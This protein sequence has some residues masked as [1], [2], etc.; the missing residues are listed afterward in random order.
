M[1]AAWRVLLSALI[2]APA[3]AIARRQYG[4]SEFLVVLKRSLLPGLVLCAH[5]ITW[6]IGARL[7]LGVNATIIVSLVPLALPVLMWGMFGEVLQKRE[8]IATLLALAGLAVLALDG[9]RMSAEH[10]LGDA[11]C[12]LSM[13]LFALYLAMARRFRNLQSL[14]LYL[15]PVY[16]VAGISSLILAPLF[17]PVMPDMTT[18]NIIMVFSLA[19]VSTVIGHSSLNFA[20]QHMRGQTVGI[21]TLAQFIFAGVLAYVL[22][23]EI[24]SL[25]FYPASGLMCLGMLLVVLNQ[26]TDK[27]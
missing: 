24:P 3:Y 17:G 10:L 12:L 22:Y 4:D 20:M 18:N 26:R 21:M 1:L 5:F 15:V 25:L 8:W 27:P 7:S 19:V 13:V 11:I 16:A 6:V 2:L 23:R 14:W 9:M